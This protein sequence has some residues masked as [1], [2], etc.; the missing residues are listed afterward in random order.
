MPHFYVDYSANMEDRADMT[1][2][3]DLLRRAAAETG[4]FPPAGIR[5]R[6]FRADHVS[7]ADGDAAH[8]YVH[9]MIRLRGG[10]A[11]DAR[12]AATD[13]LFQAARAYLAPVMDRFPVALSMEMVDI[14]PALSPKCGTIRDHLPEGWA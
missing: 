7:I 2:L 6:A 10:R 14:D 12:Q 11:L 9:V 1:G 4:L 13:H 8:G 5:V 3:C